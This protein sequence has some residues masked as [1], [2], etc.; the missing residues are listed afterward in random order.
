VPAIHPYLAIVAEDEALCHEHRF[1]AAA[2][3]ERG[4]ATALDAARAMAKT[5]IE[6]LCSADLRAAVRAEWSS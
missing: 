3:S 6:L 5:A 2:A 4:G 1:T